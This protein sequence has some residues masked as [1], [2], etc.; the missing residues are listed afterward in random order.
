MYVGINLETFYIL[1]EASMGNKF[2]NNC[3]FIN[4]GIHLKN[5]HCHFW[6]LNFVDK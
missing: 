6:N 1:Y 2:E 5:N 3:D 4:W